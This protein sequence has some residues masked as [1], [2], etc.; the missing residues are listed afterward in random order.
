MNRMSYCA[1]V[2]TKH[3]LLTIASNLLLI[4]RTSL[5]KALNTSDIYW[6]LY[7]RKIMLCYLQIHWMSKSDWDEFLNGIYKYNTII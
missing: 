6:Y 4:Y 5:Y 7:I 3:V 1:S 2:S